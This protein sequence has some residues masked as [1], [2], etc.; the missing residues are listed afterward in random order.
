[1]YPQPRS[2]AFLSSIIGQFCSAEFCTN[3]GHFFTRLSVLGAALFLADVCLAAP[4]IPGENNVGV[5]HTVTH[6]HPAAY[7]ILFL[8]FVLSMVNLVLQGWISAG[9]WP[10]SLVLDLV[11]RSISTNPEATGIK[12]LRRAGPRNA[13]K[14]RPHTGHS[15]ED[16]IVSVR[17]ILN[18]KDNASIVRTP[19][20]LEGV[21]HPVPNFASTL[22]S[23][24]GA[25]RI[26]ESQ[27]VKKGPTPEFRFSSAVD[28]P[29]TEEMERREKEQ[30]VVSGA[31]KDLEGHGIPSVIVYL[32]DEG[33]NRVGQ[34]CRTAAETGEFKVLINETG[35]YVING[36]KRGFIMESRDP[37]T[38]PIESGK[39]EGFNFRMIPEGCLV[40]GRL[41]SPS[42][43]RL[44]EGHEVRCYCGNGDFVRTGLS[45][46]E[47]EFRITGVLLNSKCFIE[48]L[49]KDGALLVR[50][51]PFETV[52]KK[53]IYREMVIPG[54]SAVDDPD[55]DET[56]RPDETDSVASTAPRSVAP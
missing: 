1:M 2:I 41:L 29:S 55:S 24:T 54:E 44:I 27:R 46:A 37:L 36:Y 18:A 22:G 49:G 56:S 30:I 52:Q 16:G 39:I 42:G 9:T 17:R 3:V 25:P 5:F 14:A 34:S 32:T 20:P 26:L 11:Q 48:I 35:K 13:L 53:E 8:I 10:I 40:Q 12:G 33:G 28:L 51:D 47:G 4:S 15:T 50:S 45:D 7:F 31:V 38:L 43:A 19:T 6:L 23:Q 21:N